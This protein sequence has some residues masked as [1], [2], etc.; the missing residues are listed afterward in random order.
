MVGEDA[1]DPILAV[2][3]R[4]L[5]RDGERIARA[6]SLIRKA[7]TKLASG[8]ALS[9]DDLA[10][11]TQETVM[12]THPTVKEL[13]DVMNPFKQRHFTA[14]DDASLREWGS[15]HQDLGKTGKALM[16]EAT[17]LMTSGD[18]TSAAAMDFAR[19]YQELTKQVLSGSSP[20][21]AL[22]P[23]IKAMVDDARSDPEASRKLEVF[24][25]IEK[26]VAN[27]KAQEGD[28]EVSRT[29]KL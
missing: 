7:R 21:T 29:P 20:V 12:T 6:L 2:Q 4:A 8:A 27:L 10:N 28:L 3:E 9:I 16:E 25:F 23:K 13:N 1:L 14:Q 24:G 15:G 11:L 19:R 22:K 18:A 5:A 26:V 17:A